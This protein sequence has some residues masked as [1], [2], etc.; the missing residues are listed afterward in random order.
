MADYVQ[1]GFQG[2]LN[3][4][5]DPTRIGRNEY[6]LLVNGRSRY[7]SIQPIFDA[8]QDSS[9]PAGI[10]QGIYAAG[11]YVLL[12]ISGT[13]WYKNFNFPLSNFQQVDEFQMDSAIDTIY[14]ELVPAST[15]NYGRVPADSNV[16]GI[17]NLRGTAMASPS[18]VVCQDGINQPRL[19]FPTGLTRIARS[20]TGWTMDA[21]EYVPV[22]LQMMY[23][24][25][26]LYIVSPDGAELFRSVTGRPLDFV[27]NIGPDGNKLATEQLGGARSVSYKVDYDPISCIA[28]LPTS[29]DSIGAFFVGTV[30]NSYRVTP[31]FQNTIFGEP[32]FDND[33]LFPTGPVNQFSFSDVVGDQVLIDYNGVR[34]FNAIQQA[35]NEGRNMPFSARIFP[36][37]QGIVQMHGCI[38]KFDNYALFGL[39]TIHGP[40]VG[41][42]DELAQRWVAIDQ[43]SGVGVV[44]QFCEIKTGATRRLFFITSDNQFFEAFGAPSVAPTQLYVGDFCS[45]DPKIGQKNMLL[46]LVFNELAGAGGTVTV[47]PF[48]NSKRQVDSVMTK[49]IEATPIAQTAPTDIPFGTAD[50]DR[51]RHLSFDCGRTMQGWQ[52]GFLISW[53]FSGNLSHL[54]LTAEDETEDN[55]LREQ[56]VG[57]AEWRNGT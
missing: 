10:Y 20:Y 53:D 11:A 4:Q 6:P 31:D 12:F 7:D 5:F 33:T 54:S 52:L 28:R 1:T 2:G 24:S 13:A 35:R 19:I 9:L 39:N 25:G 30:R 38:G 56:A 3:R 22:G 41:V 48:V 8:L 18:A 36:L 44:K 50:Q 14:A 47:S 27:V 16:N 15:L 29:P 49:T 32:Q 43:Y 42:Y 40:A 51:V 26:I 34:S 17:V 23:N 21:R 57:F 55:S 46:R 45:N 37:L